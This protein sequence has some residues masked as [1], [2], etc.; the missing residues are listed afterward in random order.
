MK[1]GGIRPARL[2]QTYDNVSR[3][4]QPHL[5]QALSAHASSHYFRDGQIACKQSLSDRHYFISAGAAKQSVTHPD[6]R[7]QIIDIL[8]PG[9]FSNGTFQSSHGYMLQALSDHTLTVCYSR[10]H[11]DALAA[12]DPVVAGQLHQMALGI[13]VRWKA[14]LITL[15][16]LTAIGKVSS[17]ILEMKA[18][19]PVNGS[20][21]FDLPVSR[22]DIANYLGISVET[23]CRSLSSLRERGAIYFLGSRRL[24]VPNPGILMTG[25]R[26]E[27]AARPGETT[28]RGSIVG[29]VQ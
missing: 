8:L 14:H 27:E 9:D 20:G 25:M 1:T 22:Y 4:A 3:G 15:G 28:G 24:N 23:V 21:T 6:G 2:R 29:I 12:S 16:Q 19:L 10:R 26:S 7:D 18:R 13:L 11:V 5:L 17:F